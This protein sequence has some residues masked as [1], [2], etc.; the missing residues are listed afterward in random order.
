MRLKPLLPLMAG[1]AALALT[2][3][4]FHMPN[5]TSLKE[6]MPELIVTGDYHGDFY[7]LVVDRLRSLGIKVYSQ[8]TSHTPKNDPKNPLPALLVPR[9]RIS[10]PLTTINARA[11]ALEYSLI[12]STATTLMLP[13]HRP[14]LMRNAITRTYLNKSTKALASDNEREVITDETLEELAAQLVMRLGYL[15]RMSD[16]SIQVATPEELVLAGD[17]SDNTVLPQR[18]TG[19]TLMEALQAQ[20]LEEQQN[21][22]RVTLD[23]LNNGNAV[24]ERTY[25]L[26]K[27]PVVRTNRAPDDLDEESQGF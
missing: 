17:G 11:S 23:E 27:V 13:K 4:G 2:A 25:E 3:C 20:D 24:L 18:K 22:T 19:V 1:I 26:P 12:V 9:P 5:E 8:D 14:I 16:P 15:G 21:G 6:V 7:K 10:R